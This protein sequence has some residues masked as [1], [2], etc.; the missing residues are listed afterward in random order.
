MSDRGFV[1][2]CLDDLQTEQ[3]KL[4]KAQKDNARHVQKHREGVERWRLENEQRR[5]RNE[6]LLPE[7]PP[8]VK[9]LEMPTQLPTL[10]MSNHVGRVTENISSVVYDNVCRSYFVSYYQ[11]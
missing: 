10:L 5:V 3:E 11:W 9:R 1:I 2:G 8:S 7:L 6:E 4:M